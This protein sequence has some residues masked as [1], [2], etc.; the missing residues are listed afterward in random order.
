MENIEPMLLSILQNKAL[1]YLRHE[2]MKQQVTIWISG[3][4]NEELALRLFSLEG[5][6]PNEI[7]S[8]EAMDIVQ[9]TL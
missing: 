2:S 9:R 6:N 8:K 3:K 1:G 4:Q 5:R 7:F